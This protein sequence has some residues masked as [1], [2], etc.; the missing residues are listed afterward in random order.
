MKAARTLPLP[1]LLLFA[2]GCAPIGDPTDLEI[3]G[4]AE[5]RAG[6]MP[7]TGRDVEDAYVI[8]PDELEVIAGDRIDVAFELLQPDVVT[9]APG[10]LPESAVWTSEPDGGRLQWATQQSDIGT[11]DV[12]FLLIDVFD[13]GAVLAQKN[14]LIDVVPRYSLIEYGF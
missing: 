12:V 11:Y 4:F 13:P 10:E 9:L 6:Q 1:A 8:G 2:M 3:V 5:P 7:V 14:L